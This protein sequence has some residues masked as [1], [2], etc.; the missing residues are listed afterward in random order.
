MSRAWLLGL[1]CFA[2]QAESLFDGKSLQGWKET[3]FSQHGPVRVEDG[4]IVLGAQA[5]AG[6]GP[7]LSAPG[8]D[9]VARFEWMF[10]AAALAFALA[11]L[12]LLMMEERPLRGGR[13]SV[14][15]Q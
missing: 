2:I 6:A 1:L 11:F 9:L 5:G 4:A 7:V 12:L 15:A 8:G 14:P 13:P 3:P 10:V